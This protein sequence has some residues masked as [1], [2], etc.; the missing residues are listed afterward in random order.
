MVPLYVSLHF[1][2]E[3]KPTVFLALGEPLSFQE[4]YKAHPERLATAFEALRERTH[5]SIARGEWGETLVGKSPRVR[6]LTG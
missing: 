4:S 3:R 6:E 2:N 1:L 5:A